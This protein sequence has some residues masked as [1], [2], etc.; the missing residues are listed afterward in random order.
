MLAQVRRDLGSNRRV[1]P[2]IA[3]FR[4]PAAQF[5]LGS[6]MADHRRSDFDAR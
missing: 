3:T 5:G 6:F 2:E 4:E 1:R